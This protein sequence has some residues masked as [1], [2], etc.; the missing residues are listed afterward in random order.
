MP[1]ALAFWCYLICPTFLHEKQLRLV[2]DGDKVEAVAQDYKGRLKITK[3]LERAG[4]EFIGVLQQDDDG[5]YV[6]L[7]GANAHQPITL[8][9]E[10]VMAHGA[11]IGDSVRASIIDMPTYQEFA[12]GK[13]AELLSNLNDRELIIENH[14]L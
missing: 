4:T 14:A 5:Y 10:D 1:R 3:V 9:A 6:Q 13:I 7:S 11:T 12:T 8:T 2:F